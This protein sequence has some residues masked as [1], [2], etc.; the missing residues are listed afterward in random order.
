MIWIEKLQPEYKAALLDISI[1]P[2]QLPFV[3]TAAEF[4]ADKQ[5]GIHHH[6]ILVNREV[7]GFFKIDTSYFHH[8]DFCDGPALGLRAVCI[9]EK[10]QGKGIGTEFIRLLKRYL[11]KHFPSFPLIYL[12]VNC[13]NPGAFKCYRRGG[14]ADTGFL[15]LGGEYGPQH[16]MRMELK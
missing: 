14:F 10:F 2:E 3:G 16:V 11:Q 6:V 4:L 1:S 13:K 12:T 5:K 15:Y 7:I 8:Y 9:D